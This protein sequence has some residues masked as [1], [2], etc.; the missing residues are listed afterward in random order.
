MNLLKRVE[1]LKVIHYGSNRYDPTLFK[2]IQNQ[3]W[4]K[5]LGGLWTSPIDSK[6]SWK[7]WCES[8]NFHTYAL[9][10]SFTLSFKPNSK[11]LV[12][13]GL[14]DLKYLPI[15]NITSYQ[16]YIDFEKLSKSVDAIWLTD[17]GESETRYNSGI[18]L[19]G[20]D[21]ESVFIMNSDCI[22]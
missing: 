12:I 21:C 3:N 11:I 4:I 7:D 8:E 17:K 16:K 22:Y 1:E 9:D 2:P 10:S 13:D 19:Y 15:Q 14:K 20:W 18:N 5:P 6:R